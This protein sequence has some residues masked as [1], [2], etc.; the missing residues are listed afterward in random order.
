MELVP[1][2]QEKVLLANVDGIFCVIGDT[3]ATNTANRC[4]KCSSTLLHLPIPKF[5]C[6]P[7]SS[8][9]VLMIGLQN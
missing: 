6:L 7:V 8:Y 9:P 4:F 5:C 2:D 3:I 1:L